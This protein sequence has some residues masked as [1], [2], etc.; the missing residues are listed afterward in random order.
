M[1]ITI[2]APNSIFQLGIES[3]FM[4]THTHTHPCTCAHSPLQLFRTIQSGTI[5]SSHTNTPVPTH[6]FLE[7]KHT[8]SNTQTHNT[9]CSIF[10]INYRFLIFMYSFCCA[11]LCVTMYEKC[12]LNKDRFDSISA[13]WRMCLTKI[14]EKKLIVFSFSLP[15]ANAHMRGTCLFRFRGFVRRNTHRNRFTTI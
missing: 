8:L 4:H 2:S 15:C 14:H 6:T 10:Y 7:T 11:E 5:T 13:L 9:L 3:S 1:M 12:S